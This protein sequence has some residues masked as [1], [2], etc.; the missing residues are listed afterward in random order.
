MRA[1]VID[2]TEYP[3][4]TISVARRL[5]PKVWNALKKGSAVKF[6]GSIDRLEVFRFASGMDFDCVE[7]KEARHEPVLLNEVLKFLKPLQGK[8]I[9]DATAGL[10]GHTIAIA[11]KV[12]PNGLVI[13]IEKD[14][15]TIRIAMERIKSPN[16]YFYQGEFTEMEIAVEEA[17]VE[18]VDA[19]LFDLGLSSFLLEGSGRGF[20]FKREEPLDMRFDPT[21]G[22]PADFY[23]NRLSE[24]ELEA[25]IRL[26]GEER[27]ARRIARAICEEREK[28]PIATTS[29]LNK[30]IE[31][32][33]RKQHVLKAKTRVY[34]A[35][36]ILVNDELNTL[37]AGLLA[38]LRIL[39]MGGIILVISYHSLEDRIVKTLSKLPGVEALSKKPVVPSDEEVLRNRRA[40]SAKLRAIKKVGEIDEAL[41]DSI[42]GSVIPSPLPG[43]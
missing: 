6:Y 33:V 32:V 28:R 25:V 13:A 43:R 38:A 42:L 36:R 4:F 41:F 11:E 14:P 24:R 2:L 8:I 12:G 29:D 18:S 15:E 17:G 34:Q 5:I 31:S 21:K 40:R 37:K 30:V 10:G 22:R 16:I 19:V 7:K 1:E 39:K 27:F 9:V 3:V 35:F 23:I 20:S 26:Y